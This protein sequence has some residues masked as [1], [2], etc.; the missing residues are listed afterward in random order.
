MECVSFF[1]TL[2]K[3][4]EESLIRSQYESYDFSNTEED[5]VTDTADEEISSTKD[6]DYQDPFDDLTSS[7]KTEVQRSNRSQRGWFTVLL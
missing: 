7:K 1:L 3:K 6:N 2:K 5:L 4:E